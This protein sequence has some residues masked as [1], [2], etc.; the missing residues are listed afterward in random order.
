M[1]VFTARHPE[2][3]GPDDFCFALEGELVTMPMH[4][5]ADPASGCGSSMAGLVS[6]QATTGFT[7]TELDMSFTEYVSALRDGFTRQG[8]WANERDDGWLIT[9]AVGLARAAEQLPVGMPL[10][11]D[12]GEIYFRV[13]AT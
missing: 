1:K 6:A 9:E 12:Q 13:S 8:W 3:S 7:V 2:P 11:I 5:C 4:V 10:G